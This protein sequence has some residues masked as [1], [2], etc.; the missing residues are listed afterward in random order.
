MKI[1]DIKPLH[2]WRAFLGEVGIIVL[3][4][5]V[6]LVV[7]QF[8]QDWQWQQDVASARD[9]LNAEI[10]A[11]LSFAR[12]RVAYHDC[13]QAY[14]A[15]IRKAATDPAPLKPF[16]SSYPLYMREW[17]SNSW[18]VVNA[19]QASSHMEREQMLKYANVFSGA[20]M[21]SQWNA[22]EF[23]LLAD[24]DAPVTD[25][26]TGRERI[27]LAAQR[28]TNLDYAMSV[29][30]RQFID[31]AKDLGLRTRPQDEATLRKEFVCDGPDGKPL[32]ATYKAP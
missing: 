29:G 25:Q 21:F 20:R 28:L 3:G 4:V 24:L 30:S 16:A 10:V 26:A 8:A 14:L 27:A 5:L 11:D 19:S 7:G 23:D 18:D 1:H 31:E 12:E 22:K 32:A 9:S 13:A 6:A 15:A 2:G 17:S